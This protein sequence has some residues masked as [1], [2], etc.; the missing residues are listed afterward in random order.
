MSSRPPK[1]LTLVEFSEP[2]LEREWQDYC[3]SGLPALVD[4]YHLCTAIHAF[5]TSGMAGRLSH[6]SSVPR[7]EL[8]GELDERLANHLLHYLQLQGY[9]RAEDQGWA[10]SERGRLVFT[11]VAM[12]QFGFYR[13]AYG[14][15]AE[16][17]P[18]LLRGELSYGA[19]VV[20]NAEALGRHSGTLLH[21]F[22]IPMVL[23]TLSDLDAICVLDLGCGGGRMLVDVCLRH[24][25]IHGVG[26]DIA[27]AAIESARKLAASEGL[28]DR[29]D[30]VVGDAFKPGTW[31]AQCL[32]AD[33]L[34][35]VGVLHEH[36]RDGEQAVIDILNTWADLLGKRLKRVV[37][38]EPEIRYDGAEHD[39]D[40]YLMHIFTNQ[41]FPRRHEDWLELFPKT[42][43]HCDRTIMRPASGPRLVFYELTLAD[44]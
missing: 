18:E 3:Q 26:L 14:P 10:M 36:F 17:I 5:V 7:S 11:P 8:I 2:E 31:P 1:T 37:I 16:R 9:L 40:F 43:L 20:R 4:S 25:K 34:M 39:A 13:E 42:K 29:L 28:A 38:G 15:V 32:E 35:A 44:N 33:V 27:P 23:Q 21:R 24:P 30:F 22:H 41:G 6:T 19:D 12:A